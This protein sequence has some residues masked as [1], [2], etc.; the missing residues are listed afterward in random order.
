MRR[1]GGRFLIMVHPP[2]PPFFT[3][4]SYP[5]PPTS[6][7]PPKSELSQIRE[8]LNVGPE[9]QSL[10]YYHQFLI[11]ALTTPSGHPAAAMTASFT[12][13]DRITYLTRE[14][15]E[16]KELLEDYG[17]VKLIYEALFEY[18]RALCGLEGREV[19]EG[20]KGELRGWL[21]RLRVLDPMRRGRWEDLGRECGLAGE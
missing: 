10:W 17:D 15:E 14:I 3:P 2:S 13:Q 7:T 1:R 9:D 6:L 11:L 21:G 8:A 4:L 5:Q 12:Q 18:T 20:E 19:G 16:I